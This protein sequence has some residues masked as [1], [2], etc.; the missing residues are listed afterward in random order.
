MRLFFGHSRPIAALAAVMLLLA[1]LLPALSAAQ[2]SAQ[3]DDSPWLVICSAHNP[4]SSAASRAPVSDDDAATSA[5]CPL[6]AWA[7]HAMAPPPVPGT[8]VAPG[9]LRAGP[10][11][12]FLHSG[13]SLFVWA[14]RYSRGPPTR[15]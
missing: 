4:L 10:P 7:Q 2:R 3:A 14:A 13:E 15:S 6:C 12:R 5:H 8:P 9:S 1:A 11:C